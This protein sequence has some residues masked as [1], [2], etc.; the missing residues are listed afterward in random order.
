MPNKI[1]MILR[2][3]KSTQ[4]FTVNTRTISTIST[5]PRNFAQQS[6]QKKSIGFNML[7]FASLKKSGGCSSCGGG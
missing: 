1:P 6:P 2:N 5:T 7:N 4:Q 3:S